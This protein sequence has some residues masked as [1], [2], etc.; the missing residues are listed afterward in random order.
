MKI[1][2]LNSAREPLI[3]EKELFRLWYEFYKIALTSSD[4]A[5]KTALRKSEMFYKPW[6]KDPSI[7]F[8]DWW[9]THR[10]LFVDADRVQLA[11]AG[12]KAGGVLVWVP[13]GKSETLLVEEFQDLLRT[14]PERFKVKKRKKLV[15]HPFAPTEVQG[16]KREALRMMLALQQRVFSQQKLKGHDLLERVLKFFHDER[17]KRRKNKIPAAFFVEKSTPKQ[18]HHDEAMRN[19]RRY[20]QKAANLVLN[21]A[22]GVFPGRY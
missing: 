14:A 10:A 3:A 2:K 8:D 4:K 17:Y 22:G 12:T 13:N 6:G 5:V 16:V 18:D 20:R 9:K 21:V 19:V 15:S 11:E 7:H 1:S